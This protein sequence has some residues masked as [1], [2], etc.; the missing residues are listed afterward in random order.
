MPDQDPNLNAGGDDADS[1]ADHLAAAKAAFGE[2][3]KPAPGDKSGGDAKPAPSGDDK[4]GTEPAAP[5]LPSFIKGKEKAAPDDKKG[6]QTPPPEAPE[7]DKLT[8]PDEKSKHRPDWDK[9]KAAASEHYKARIQAEARLK[10]LEAKL[11]ARGPEQ[12]DE[13]TKARLQQLEQQIKD[14]DAKLKVFDLKSHPDFQKQYVEPQNRAIASIKETMSIDGIDGD[15]EKILS[16]E[17]KK[18]AE[19][20]SELLG[21][22]SEFSKATL[23][24]LFREAKV[25]RMQEQQALGNV[26]KLR[27]EYQ[28]NFAARARATFDATAKA[29]D[30]TL[31]PAQADEKADEATKQDVAAYNAALASINKK[32]EALAF[33][34]VNE[35]TASEMAHKAARFDFM[36]EHAIPRFQKLVEA[37]LGKAYSQIAEL[38]QKLKEL[39]EANPGYKGG[40]GGDPEGGSK[41]EGDLSHLDAA[42]KYF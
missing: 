38:Q 24:Q 29:F 26:D 39:T 11:A 40:G 19:A 5:R 25:L 32:A 18:F 30:E 12:A 41:P 10:E 6:E 37:E 4:K 15:V 17:G 31:L 16:L 28:K 36:V 9:M 20:V 34:Q 23:A 3:T 27:E 13:A 8:G 14:Y 22:A 2:D 42:K 7:F 21:N 35:A 33:G 1:H